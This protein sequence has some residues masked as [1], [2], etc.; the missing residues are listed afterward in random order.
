MEGRR[1]NATRNSERNAKN[2]KRKKEIQKERAEKAKYL[3]SL[4]ALQSN[5]VT[6]YHHLE[7]DLPG[8][9]CPTTA[10]FGVGKCR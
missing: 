6:F 3:A 2:Y 7:G 10:S 4:L 5:V 1:P 9:R 8:F